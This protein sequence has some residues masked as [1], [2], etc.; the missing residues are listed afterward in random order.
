MLAGMGH[1]LWNLLAKRS[2]HKLPF[3]IIA[4]LCGT[5]LMM[6]WALARLAPIPPIGWGLIA[7]SGLIELV[8]Y[9][10]LGEAYK[11]GDM[12]LVY[13]IA[14]GSSPV[15]VALIAVL[16]F[17]ERLS[18]IG[19]LGIALGVLGVYVL[20]L[21]DLTLPS[22]RAPLA[23]LRGRAAQMA[24]GTGL[25]IALYSTVDKQGVK[26]VD[27]IV[28]FWLV[29]SVSLIGLLPW[30]W[31]RMRTEMR[32]EWRMHWRTAIFVG[33]LITGGYVL[34]LFILQHNPVSYATAV[35]SVS[36][37]FGALLGVI[38]LKEPITAPRVL[39][40]LVIFAGVVCIGLA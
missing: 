18:P 19:I 17:G 37:V 40:S 35:R 38:A 36:I 13:P 6:P 9:V 29:L 1:A 3:M 10:L 34:I 4:V 22:L 20:P 28:Y 16:L 8:Y 15:F 12:S 31:W 33:A 39:G 21:P 23:A 32:D 2:R 5:L 11:H 14:R 25:C 24:L 26:W 30:L 7:A 27:P